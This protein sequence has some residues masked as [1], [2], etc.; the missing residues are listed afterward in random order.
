[1]YAKQNSPNSNPAGTSF[2]ITPRILKKYRHK[3]PPQTLIQ[4][5]HSH[6]HGMVHKVLQGKK[7]WDVYLHKLVRISFKKMMHLDEIGEVAANEILAVLL[8]AIKMVC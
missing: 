4:E 1:M 6:Q 5:L 3:A 7:G 2:Y 8:Q